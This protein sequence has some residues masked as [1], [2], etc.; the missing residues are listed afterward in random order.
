MRFEIMAHLCDQVFQFSSFL[1][2]ANFQVLAKLRTQINLGKM[3]LT[4]PRVN[5]LLADIFIVSFFPSE[6]P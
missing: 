2:N 4:D 3:S 6:I 1:K 5:E